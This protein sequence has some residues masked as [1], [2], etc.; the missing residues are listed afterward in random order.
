MDDLNEMARLHSAGAIIRHVSPFDNLPTHKNDVDLSPDFVRKW[1]VPFYM[2][3]GRSQ[4]STW[5]DQIKKICKLP[6]F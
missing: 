3:I 6:I 5:I 2:E 1:A 4:N